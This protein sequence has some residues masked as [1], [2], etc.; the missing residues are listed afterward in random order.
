MSV[1]TTLAGLSQTASSNGPDGSVDPPSAVDDAIRYALSFIASLR[2]GKGFTTPVVLASAS[3]TD[4]GAQNSLGVEISGTTTITSFGTT[5][6]GPRF[7]RFTGALTLT[8][9]ASSLILPGG[10]NIA[11]AAGDCALAIP[12]TTAGTADGWQVLAYQRGTFVGPMP[13]YINGLTLS[14]NGSD[15]TNDIDIAV[16]SATDSTG[17][18]LLTLSSAMT[19]RLDAA[20]AVGTGNGGLDTGSIANTT[21]HIW[22]IRKDSDGSIDALFSASASAPTMPSGYTYK[23]YVGAIIRASAAILA[24]TQVGNEV[25]WK[26]SSLDFDSGANTTSSPITV[27]APLGIQTLASLQVIYNNSVAGN[28]VLYVSSTD[29]NDET[30]SLAASRATVVNPS[31]TAFG[32]ATVSVRTNTSAQIRIRSDDANNTT[33]IS[34]RGFSYIRR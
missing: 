32:A 19:K 6:N 13:G 17:A 28:F 2:D 14:N 29:Q 9:N 1:N 18:H 20:W 12:K 34:T 4:I 27:R 21:Y 5:Y 15:A 22:L 10:A 3:T 23:A 11:T 33:R 8:H 24:F 25:L 31:T 16:G 7:L 26:A 30:A